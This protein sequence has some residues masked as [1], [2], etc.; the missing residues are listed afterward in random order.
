MPEQYRVVALRFKKTPYYRRQDQDVKVLPTH[1]S[2]PGIASVGDIHVQ[3]TPL[4]AEVYLAV[5]HFAE[6]PDEF[7][8]QRNQHEEDWWQKAEDA[9]RK[10]VAPRP[11]LFR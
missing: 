6:T 1:C 5:P 4:E 9:C 8:R 2:V 11:I 10:H 7:D 3:S